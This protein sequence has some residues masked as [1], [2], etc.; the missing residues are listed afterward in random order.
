MK[1]QANEKVRSVARE[2]VLTIG[3]EGEEGAG[4][5]EACFR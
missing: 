2:S 5:G 4:A 1:E 3:I